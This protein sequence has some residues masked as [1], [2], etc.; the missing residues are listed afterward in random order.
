MTSFL[1]LTL[2]A[3]A[4]AVTLSACTMA[5]RYERPALPVPDQ[6]PTAAAAQGQSAETLPWR[7][8]FLDPRLQGVIDQALTNNRD[9]RVAVLNVERARSQYRIQRAS[10]FPAVDGTVAG[11]RGNTTSVDT[12]GN[13]VTTEVYTASLGASWELDLFGRVRSL[14]QAALQNYFAVAENRKAAQ[15]S[16]ISAV[17]SAWLN[18]A[19]DQ[20]QLRLSGETLRLREESLTLTQKR[21]DLGSTDQMTLRQTQVLTEQARADVAALTATVQQDKNALRLLVGAE[22]VADQLPETFPDNAVL[23]ELPAGQPSDV[24]LKRPD[25]MAAEYSLKAA[26]ADIGAARAAFFPRISL[27]GAVGKASTELGD[28]FDGNDT[29]T[30]S[31]SISVPI[32]AG[33]AN[34]AN[35]SAS[36]TSR[37]I[38]VAQYESAI[39]SAFRDVADELATRSTIDDRLAAQTNVV[40]AATDSNTLAQAR[41]DRGVDSR[42]TLTDSERTLYGAQQQLI[43]IRLVRSLNLINLYAALGG[44]YPAE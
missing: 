6:F 1:K 27:T 24:L 19:A 28:L 21:F 30:F 33:G 32:F 9:L 20:D 23:A 40:A 17:A 5:P 7:Q 16:L 31:P 13:P 8:V 36:K 10:L 25:V 15:I 18:L 2:L 26:N 38:A 29:W 42:L 4:G 35:L 44:G 43:T 34:I 22:V 14:N 41:F 39:Q 37:D 3:T 12:A 11:V